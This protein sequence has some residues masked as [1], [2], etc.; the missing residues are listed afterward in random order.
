MSR[1]I[2]LCPRL[3]LALGMGACGIPRSCK[4]KWGG[5]GVEGGGLGR[6]PMRRLAGERGGGGGGKGAES[7]PFSDP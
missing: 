6:G 7:E 4:V 2:S 1:D 3:L 5:G